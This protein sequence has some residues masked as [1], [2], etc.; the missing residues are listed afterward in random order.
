[1]FGL[2]MRFAAIRN[3][4]RGAILAPHRNLKAKAMPPRWQNFSSS[5]EGRR[6]H[7]RPQQELDSGTKDHLKL[8]RDVKELLGTGLFKPQT[9]V[10][11]RTK[12]RKS[13][14]ASSYR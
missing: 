5:L 4:R 8:N 3:V 7:L 9:L 13:A 2:T 12:F 6:A 1:M 14:L 11:P 10:T